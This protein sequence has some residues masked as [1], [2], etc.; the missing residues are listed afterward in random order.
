[1][2]KVHKVEV[3]IVDHDNID[4]EQVKVVIENTT[5]PNRCI[6][7]NVL[8]VKTKEVEWSDDHPLNMR[9]TKEEAARDLFSDNK[10]KLIES[11]EWALGMI[12]ANYQDTG[13]I[14]FAE[15][16]VYGSAKK[17]LEAA[18]KKAHED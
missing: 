6:S 14:G 11:L 2:V 17:T 10:D 9:S 7:P 1:M 15:A 16:I 13:E 4:T 18:K 12:D 8:K 3:L 5:Y